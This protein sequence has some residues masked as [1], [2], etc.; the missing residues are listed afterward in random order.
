MSR[1][2]LLLKLAQRYPL[3]SLL[4]I[5]LGFL[6]ALFNGISTALIVPVILSLLGQDLNV[7][8]SPPFLKFLLAPFEGV[9]SHYRL[10]V[11]AGA[12]VLAIALKNLTI[13]ANSITGGMLKRQLASNLRQESL[14]MLL[15]VDLDYF[16][17]TGVGDI[18]NRI[19]NE[20]GRAANALSYLLRIITHAITVLI[21]IGLLLAMSWKLTLVASG[22]L[23]LVVGL[24]QFYI[25]RAKVF[26]KQLSEASKA[27]SI[28]LTESLMGMRLIKESVS[29]DREYKVLTGLIRQRENLEFQSQ[30]NSSAIAPVSEMAGIIALL[31]IVGLGRLFFLGQ[32]DAVS[33][34]LL[35]YL[36]VLFRLLPVLS[37]LNG[38]RSQFANLSA[39]VAVVADFLNR[40][41][42]PFMSDGTVPFEGLNHAITVENLSF[43]YPGSDMGHAQ[44]SQRPSL[45]NINLTLPKGTTLALVGE[46]GAGKSTLADLLPR[47]YDPS[48]GSIHID[49]QDIRQFDLASL[50]RSIG[51]VSQESF[52]FNDSIFNNVAYARPDA[53][54]A[55]VVDALKRANAYDFVMELPQGLETQIGD[56]GVLLSGG[57]RQRLAIARAL[58]KNAPILI[59]DEATSALDTVSERLVQKA[60]DDLSRDRTSLVIAHRLSTIQGAEQIAVLDQGRVV[61]VGSHQE[62]LAKNGYYAHLHSVQFSETLS[63]PFAQEIEADAKVEEFASQASYAIRNNLNSMLGVL[64]LLSDGVVDSV[65]EQRDLIRG[66]HDSALALLKVLEAVETPA[67]K[68]ASKAP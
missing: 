8:S 15:A 49:G 32:L 46:S 7:G 21:F 27:Y 43:T 39:S 61:E 25:F 33:T 11:M 52:L 53:T 42:K 36:V 50:R 19:N 20:V 41:D 58:L 66:A 2:L 44:A 51:V 45:Q 13:Y 56:R 55:E 38:A 28:R 63:A 37:Q 59:L 12:I 16:H 64:S 5:V 40:H 62:L 30:A 14:Q 31:S 24:N 1:H 68:K 35:T 10:G 57:Q 22:L 3:Q 9:S 34:V 67:A 29:E 48:Q 6:G 65:E 60:I 17:K 54:Q 23:S 4:T 47:F 26:G 18:I